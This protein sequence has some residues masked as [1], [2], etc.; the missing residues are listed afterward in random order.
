VH[1]GDAVEVIGRIG[2]S[3]AAIAVLDPPRTGADRA[4][5]DLLCAPGGVRRIGYVSCDPATLARDIAE[6]AARGWHLDDLRAFDAFPMTHHVECLAVLS[7]APA[8]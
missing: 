1:R 7:P 2:L 8:G 6:F 5:I 3:G 4:L